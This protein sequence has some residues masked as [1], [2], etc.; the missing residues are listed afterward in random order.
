MAQKSH[1]RGR[2][3]QIGC[4]ENRETWSAADHGERHTMMPTTTLSAADMEASTL[5]AASNGSFQC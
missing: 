2:G 5:F 3:S 1:G 4:N